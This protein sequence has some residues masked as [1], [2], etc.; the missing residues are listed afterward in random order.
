MA[1]GHQLPPDDPVRAEAHALLDRL[2]DLV[3]AQAA[4]PAPPPPP[5][6]V[7]PFATACAVLGWKP[8]RLRTFCLAQGVTITGAGKRAAVDLD[9]VRAALAAQ[10]RLKHDAP[11]KVQNDDL[12]DWLG[13]S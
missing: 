1:E 2:L 8:R 10:P 6:G 7:M 3:R 5:G 9:A 11:S 12:N 4:P 13:K